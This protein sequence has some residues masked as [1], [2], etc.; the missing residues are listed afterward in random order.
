MHSGCQMKIRAVEDGFSARA[1]AM[2]AEMEAD[3]EALIEKQNRELDFG[4][5]VELEHLLNQ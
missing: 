1:R 5:S 4:E 2:G 3:F